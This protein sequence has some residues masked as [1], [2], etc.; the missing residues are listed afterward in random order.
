M[1]CP[2][3]SAPLQ[4]GGPRCAYCGSYMDVDLEG[5]ARAEVS[6][7]RADLHCP[8]GHGPLE[9]IQLSHP[10]PISLDRCPTCLGLFLE[11]G[12]L[13]QLLREAV[14]PV[15]EVDTPL[16]NSLVESPHSQQGALR[17][18]PCPACGDMMNRSLFG[19]RSGVIIDRCRS[20]GTWLDPGELRQLLEWT[21]AG[22][23]LRHQ[24][25]SEQERR[26]QELRETRTA[27]DQRRR[28]EGLVALEASSPQRSL[29]ETDLLVLLSRSLRQLWRVRE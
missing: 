13:Q 14:G 25:Q 18:R 4:D 15:W 21:R 26:Q 11:H 20:H 17:Y 29:L 2:C 7:P 16:L 10:S 12:S 22:G 23:A 6:G 1:N 9:A 3:C 19:K 28:C 8:D 27:E 24:E 5:W